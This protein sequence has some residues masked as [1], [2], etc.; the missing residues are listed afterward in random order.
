MNRDRREQS[1]ISFLL[2]DSE[3]KLYQ[4]KVIND[5]EGGYQ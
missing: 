5:C 1:F 4:N 3:R 2:L